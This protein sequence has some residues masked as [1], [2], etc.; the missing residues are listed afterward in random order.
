MSRPLSSNQDAGR[1]EYDDHDDIEGYKSDY[2]DNL[3]S[4]DDEGGDDENDLMM[5]VVVVMKPN[6]L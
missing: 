3:D 2:G 6:L 5:M 4:Y 1:A